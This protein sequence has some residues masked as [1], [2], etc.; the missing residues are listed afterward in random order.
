MTDRLPVELPDEDAPDPTEQPDLR[1][2]IRAMKRRDR[3]FVVARILVE[4]FARADGEDT[5]VA[6]RRYRRAVAI[7]RLAALKRGQLAKSDL[8]TLMA[9]V[10]RYAGRDG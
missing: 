2:L 1:A 3:Q 10:D 9:E 6:W 4:E 8:P 7:E 5:A